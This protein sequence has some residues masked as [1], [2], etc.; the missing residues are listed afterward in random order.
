VLLVFI[1]LTTQTDFRKVKNPTLG[2]RIINVA[3]ILFFGFTTAFWSQVT[4]AE[5]YSL[6]LF[7]TLLLAYLLLIWHKE[8]R[9][10][11]PNSIK[12]LGLIF[13]VLGIS[14]TIHSFF[15]FSLIP[16]FFL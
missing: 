14:L 6:N 12:W 7:F 4:R 9:A 3:I 11:S 8:V 16:A 5:V 15:I 1:L 2:F 13:F 10:H